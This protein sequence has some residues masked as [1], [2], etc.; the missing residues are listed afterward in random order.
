MCYIFFIY[1]ILYL[2]PNT[3]NHAEFEHLR[4]VLADTGD[5]V[6]GHLLYYLGPSVIYGYIG[7]LFL[8]ELQLS[9]YF[10]KENLYGSEW[11]I[12]LLKLSRSECGG[13][14]NSSS[15]INELNHIV[16]G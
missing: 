9:L 6:V 10:Y 1:Y 16:Y 2:A 8:L 4:L 14:S 7:L 12:L 5:P 13:S 15:P 11:Y 3:N